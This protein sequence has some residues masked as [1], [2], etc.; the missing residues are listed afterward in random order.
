MKNRRQMGDK[1]I[2]GRQVGWDI[3]R[4]EDRLG[5]I[6]RYFGCQFDVMVFTSSSPFSSLS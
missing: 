6:I 3:V 2:R 1:L 5:V 4:S